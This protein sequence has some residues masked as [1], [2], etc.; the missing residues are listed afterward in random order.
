[1]TTFLCI[2]GALVIA[3]L[4]SLGLIIVVA[5]FYKALHE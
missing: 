4:A 5:A 1:M 2:V 3:I